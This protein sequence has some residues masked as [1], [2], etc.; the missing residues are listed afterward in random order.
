MTEQ[1]LSTPI[2]LLIVQD[3][4]WV[5]I[6]VTSWN[7]RLIDWLIDDFPHMGKCKYSC[8][9]EKDQISDT[10]YEGRYINKS[11]GQNIRKTLCLFYIR[12]PS[13][14][15]LRFNYDLYFFPLWFFSNI[16]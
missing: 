11:Y 1:I 6:V 9:E 13:N 12:K 5:L 2:L 14:F 4:S 10:E 3:L 16:Q 15:T 7:H 8:N